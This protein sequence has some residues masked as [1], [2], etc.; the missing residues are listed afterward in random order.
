MPFELVEEKKTGA[1]SVSSL[2]RGTR[3]TAI[4]DLDAVVGRTGLTGFSSRALC[5]TVRGGVFDIVP[6]DSSSSS[7]SRDRARRGSE[8]RKIMSSLG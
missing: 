7:S 5:A 2:D 1:L 4:G 3:D 6:G 8:K